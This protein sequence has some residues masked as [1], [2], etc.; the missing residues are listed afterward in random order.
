MYRHVSQGGSSRHGRT[1][2][3]SGTLYPSLPVPSSSSSSNT[4]KDPPR[5]RSSSTSTATRSSSS[6]VPGTY[7]PLR[8]LSSRTG[9]ALT[10]Q[11]GRTRTSGSRHWRAPPPQPLS[12][13]G[14]P[15]LSRAPRLGPP[16]RLPHIRLHLRLR[17]RGDRPPRPHPV[18]QS[19]RV[20]L[21]QAQGWCT[22]YRR[23][24]PRTR[25]PLPVHIS[26]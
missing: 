1:H 9:R 3:Q 4:A 14:L 5:V 23:R 17:P 10:W 26:S 13:L 15:Q 2:P 22:S 12:R 25:S 6:R 19:R 20:L 7:V 21:P 8:C 11:H 24:N 16:H 18:R